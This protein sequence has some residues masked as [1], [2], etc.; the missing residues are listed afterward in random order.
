MNHITK[1]IVSVIFVEKQNFSIVQLKIQAYSIRNEKKK[2][3][4]FE[5]DF[6]TEY[7]Y[8]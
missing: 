7:I 6:K 3:I 8:N 4:I 2:K 1:V 5:I